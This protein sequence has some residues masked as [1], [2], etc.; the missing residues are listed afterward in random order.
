MSPRTGRRPGD[1]DTRQEILAAA[2]DRF[3]HDGFDRTSMRGVARQAG[4]DPALVHHYFSDK[5][6]LFVAAMELPFEPADMV[7]SVVEGPLDG[8]GER[9]VRLFL[10]VWDGPGGDH[11]VG[12]LRAAAVNDEAARMLREFITATVLTGVAARLDVDQPEVRAALC[13]AQIVGAGV[14]RRIVQLPPLVALED[15]A[16]VA[17][18]APTLQR[19]LTA[20]SPTGR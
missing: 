18:L 10:Q 14:L 1:A 3:I 11:L 17:W 2:R 7:A 20:P 4:V 8:I 19:Y 5:T 15:E 9:L 6:A 16:L 12:L 13:G